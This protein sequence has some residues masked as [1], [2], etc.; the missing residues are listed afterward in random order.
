VET[1]AH[2]LAAEV[3]GDAANR[4]MFLV[5]PEAGF[6]YLA[7]GIEN[8][9]PHD[10]PAASSIGVEQADA[11]GRAVIDGRVRRACFFDRDVY[12]ASGLWPAD[13]VRALQRQMRPAG[14]LGP[15]RVWVRRT[16][17]ASASP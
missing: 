8:P 2:T 13:A 15:C 1:V 12:G 4:S 5:A 10:F 16:S 7:A 11:L 14:S 17:P 3:R 6:L 9:T